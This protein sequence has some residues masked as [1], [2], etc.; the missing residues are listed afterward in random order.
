V[1]DTGALPE[2]SYT[3]ADPKLTADAQ[4]VF[5]VGNDSAAFDA[6]SDAYSF[7]AVDQDG[8]PREG[9]KE[10]GADEFSSAPVI[11]RILTPAD[12]G[13]LSQ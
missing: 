9:K 13:P 8:Q 11:A 1:N 6:A 10:I 3:I 4:G 2:G 12:V 7:V 5:R